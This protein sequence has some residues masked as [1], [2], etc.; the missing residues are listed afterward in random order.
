MVELWTLSVLE[1]VD[2]SMQFKVS[3]PKR[4]VMYQVLYV[5]KL[6][7]NLF[8]VRAAA[9]IGNFLKFGKSKCWIRNSRGR[10]L[11]MGYLV[12]KLYQLDCK[13][14]TPEYA[15]VAAR[16]QQEES[17]DLWHQRLGHVNQQQI[18]DFASQDIV[19]GVRVLKSPDITFCE[20]CVQGKMQREKFAQQ[21]S[22]NAYTV[23]CVVPCQRS[24]LEE[25]SILS[26]SLMTSQSVAK[27]T[28]C[29]TSSR[30]T[31]HSQQMNVV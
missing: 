15:S 10:L 14:T 12:G 16:N 5:L 1:K 3:D 23:M 30:N 20:S 6:A 22:W 29:D 2:L 4:C 8:S 25:K 21:E 19:K 18:Y 11:G 31:K 9:S 24:P 27:F 26:R 7:C 28:S 13:T 17:A